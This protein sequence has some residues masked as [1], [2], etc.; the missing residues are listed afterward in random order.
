MKPRI[1]VVIPTD[2]FE[3]IE[4]VIG[5]LGRQTARGSIELVVVT[6]S[7]RTLAGHEPELEGFHSIR[8]VEAETASLS[9]ARAAGTRAASSDL[10]AF[11]ESHSFPEP[12]WAEA[13]IAAHEGAWAAVGPAMV[14]PHRTGSAGWVDFMIDYG[15]WVPPVA[16]GPVDDLPG[17]NSS[18]KRALLLDYGTEL[19]GMLDAEWLLHK[20]LRRRGYALYL[21]P[22][23]ETRHVS[24]SKLL[25]S[26]VQWF[27]Y[28]RGFA[29]S[30]SRDW[31]PW[32]RLVYVAGSPLI[33]LVRL[34]R[35]MTA[36]RRT[37]QARLIV[38]TLPLTL[39]TLTGSAAG[40]LVGYAVGGGEGSER[41]RE[42][43]LHRNR[44]THDYDEV[45]APAVRPD[46][47]GGESH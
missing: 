1:S 40:E 3:T 23:A 35:V 14:N 47:S 15:Q 46:A 4:R 26:I 39:L 2:R 11:T 7:A 25:P 28:S 10:V 38:P 16:P 6:P 5:S 31:T 8:V 42:Y 44:Y 32:R 33:V 29:T 20:D 30:R 27:H 19:E 45:S 36:M 24:P 22:A 13:L 17:H 9:R 12:G 43:E 18:Y 34:R 37:G 41:G 21:E